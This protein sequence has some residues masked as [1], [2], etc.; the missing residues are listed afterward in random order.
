MRHMVLWSWG[1]PHE[2]KLPTESFFETYSFERPSP[3]VPPSRRRKASNINTG[4]WNPWFNEKN[5]GKYY[6]NGDWHETHTYCVTLGWHRHVTPYGSDFVV[7]TK[8]PHREKPALEYARILYTPPREEMK[9]PRMLVL[10]RSAGSIQR[11]ST[12]RRQLI[13]QLKDFDADPPL[14][15]DTQSGPR[16]AEHISAEL[17]PGVANVRPRPDDAGSETNHAQ[18]NPAE[19]AEARANTTQ[20]GPGETEHWN[21]D[22]FVM[23]ALYTTFLVMVEETDLFIWQCY[24]ERKN[25]SSNKSKYLLHLMD[26]AKASLHGVSRGLQLLEE[27]ESSSVTANRQQLNYNGAALPRLPKLKGTRM[28]KLHEQVS[29]DLHFQKSQTESLLREL[30]EDQD[31]LRSRFQLTQD[32]RFFTLNILAAVFLPLSFTTSL[33]GMNINSDT[34]DGPGGLSN[35]TQSALEKLSSIENRR[36]TEILS[37][38]TATSGSLT[39]SW[40]TFGITAACLLTIL[41]FSFILGASFR[42][43]V[44][45]V[46]LSAIYWRALLLA[47]VLFIFW[48]SI[49]GPYVPPLMSLVVNVLLMATSLGLAWRK[50]KQKRKL[51]F[52][53][54]LSVLFAVDV[55]VYF[56][57]SPVA[58]V[59]VV[60]LP[61]ITIGLVGL[62]YVRNFWSYSSQREF[63]GKERTESSTE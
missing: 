57:Q 27:I 56:H 54:G 51:A 36:T 12:F 10:I 8:E 59:I 39:F 35:W 16:N 34:K 25:P 37:S 31:L 41:P 23:A 11:F 9:Q 40:R 46:A 1:I 62:L 30:S 55:A 61:W 53:L 17:G 50:K 28:V 26:L 18:S 33:F 2:D 60:W 22:E 5:L 48:V 29:G 14:Q 15:A 52:W 49:S 58:F 32:R 3:L 13:R 43:I 6:D 38:V 20:P 47:V 19:T 24:K 4:F 63:C 7:F 45:G 21:A 44:G 42:A